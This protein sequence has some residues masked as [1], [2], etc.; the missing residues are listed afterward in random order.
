M[1]LRIEYEQEA[2]EASEELQRSIRWNLAYLCASS[3]MPA[4]S[5]AFW[6]EACAALTAASVAGG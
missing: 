4:E 1:A 6:L 2:L 3:D 5:I